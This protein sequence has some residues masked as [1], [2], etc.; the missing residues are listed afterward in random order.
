MPGS[1]SSRTLGELAESTP[2]E[3][4]LEANILRYLA[5]CIERQRCLPEGGVTITLP[6]QREERRLGFDAA[7]DLSPGRYA[8]LQFKRPYEPK[9]GAASFCIQTDQFS[10]LLRYPPA[11]AFYVL[12]AVRTNRDMWGVRAGLLDRAC[13]IDAW[14]LVV[15]LLATGR[16][17]PKRGGNPFEEKTRTIHVDGCCPCTASVFVKSDCKG[18]DAARRWRVYAK[19][20]RALC[21][22]PPWAGFVV[23]GGRPGASAPGAGRG[24]TAAGGAGGGRVPPGGTA[25]KIMT[26]GGAEWSRKEASR[27]LQQALK[28]LPPSYPEYSMRGAPAYDDNDLGSWAESILDYAERSG[29]TGHGRGSRHVLG[30]G[31]MP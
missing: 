16:P 23:V 15:P 22:H 10:T 13:L 7:A 29:G 5:A 17:L 19:P 18:N 25:G 12:P 31:N 4:G 28:G 27:L 26:A 20:A 9:G 3:A 11:S 8:V 6:T 1:R 14:D 24:G 2:S 21:A 30:F